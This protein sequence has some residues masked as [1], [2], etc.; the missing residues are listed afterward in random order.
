VW[1]VTFD[2]SGALGVICSLCLVLMPKKSRQEVERCPE[3]GAATL[4]LLRCCCCYIVAATLLLLHCCCFIVASLL[5]LH[6]CCYIVA[7]TLLLLHCCTFKITTT[8]CF[9]ENKYINVSVNVRGFCSS[10]TFDLLDHFKGSSD[11]DESFSA[12]AAET[13][14]HG[15]GKFWSDAVFCDRMDFILVFLLSLALS[16]SLSLSLL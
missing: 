2:L 12:S 14:K 1:D 5:L 7:A 9:D 15:D 3:S 11:A 16:L 10:L 4:L 13:V 8:D 6:C